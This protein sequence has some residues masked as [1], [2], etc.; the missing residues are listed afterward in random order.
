MAESGQVL[1][2][3]ADLVD[4]GQVPRVRQ[5]FD[6][7]I[8]CW[9]R[10][11]WKAVGGLG[12][13]C[14]VTASVGG[15]VGVGLVVFDV[16]ALCSLTLLVLAHRS[17]GYREAVAH[18]DERSHSINLRALAGVGVILTVGNL[19][20][21][22]GELASGRSGNPYYWMVMVAAIAYIVFIMLFRRTS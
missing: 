10:K 22:I 18:P 7:G 21:F 2:S 20:A 12:V 19:S 14:L 4:R 3:V 11:V 16:M 5:D 6:R 13:F 1:D 15:H 8:P 9:S 17:E